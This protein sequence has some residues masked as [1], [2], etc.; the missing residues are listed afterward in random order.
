MQVTHHRDTA[1]QAGPYDLVICRRVLCTIADEAEAEALVGDLRRAVKAEGRVLL[2]VC[3]PD[4][5]CLTT[6]DATGHRPA[7]AAPER[8]LCWHKT[9]KRT[10]RRLD[11]H[12]PERILR[13]L[14]SRASLSVVARHEMETLDLERFEPASDLLILELTPIPDRPDVTLMIKA[15]AMEADTT[16]GSML[17][18]DKHRTYP[19][20]FVEPRR[21]RGGNVW[22]YLRS[23]RK[24]LFDAI[25]DEA[26]RL[27]GRYVDLANDWAY[28]L[29][30][31][32]LAHRPVHIPEPL[33]L[34]EPSG[35]GKHAQ[36][37]HRE[38]MIARIVASPSLHPRTGSR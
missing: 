5:A 20:D 32:E 8:A 36:R 1:V 23:F 2:A 33:Y 22:Q 17:R 35:A 14:L 16:I 13:R 12:R 30:I 6:P 34:H 29:P 26:L 15:C 25:P 3:H 19:V 31:V 24:S 4:Y 10:G 37:G 21:R 28:M 38:T 27:D 7:D 11:V 9:M 18:T